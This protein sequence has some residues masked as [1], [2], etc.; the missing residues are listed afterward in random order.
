M[1]F[2]LLLI[3]TLIISQSTSYQLAI[4][5]TNYEQWNNK[6]GQL[7]AYG[8]SN[9]E[10]K[11]LKTRFGGSGEK[12]DYYYFNYSPTEHLAEYITFLGNNFGYEIKSTNMRTHN[13]VSGYFQT[14]HLEKK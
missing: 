8:L 14:Y 11:T 1:K 5:E 7:Y 4:I 9:D 12:A 10:I 6:F 13:S 2:V 3:S